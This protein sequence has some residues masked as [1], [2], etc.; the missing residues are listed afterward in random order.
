MSE[1]K[2]ALITGIWGQDGWYLAELLLR[3]GYAVTGTTH[4]TDVDPIMNVGGHNVPIVNLDLTNMD[5]VER[6]VESHQFDEIYNLASRASSTQLFDD[7]IATSEVNGV[8][9]ARFLESV[10]NHSPATRFCQASSSEVFAGSDRTVQDESTPRIPRN[11]Y[12]AAKAF[13]DHLVSAYRMTYGLFACSAVL[14]SHESPRRSPHFVVRKIT[15]AAAR[16]AAGQPSQVTL[17]NLV[18]SRDWGYAPDYADAM[19]R[20]LQSEVPRDYV[21]ATGEAHTV[22]D[23]CET[24]FGYVEVD[25]R[26]HVAVSDRP[27]RDPDRVVRVGDSR[28]AAADL[29]WAPTLDFTQMIIEMVDADVGLLNASRSPDSDPHVLTD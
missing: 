23:V 14:F 28:R 15:R 18:S 2:G 3:S 8:A 21:I 16:V 20:M 11:A 25:W 4:R 27:Q 10:K 12:G 17:E 26:D 13:G 24:A 7:P 29:G 9:V 1:R 5:Q 6:L 19:R 22:Q